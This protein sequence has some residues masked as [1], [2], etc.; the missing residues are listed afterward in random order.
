MRRPHYG[1]GVMVCQYGLWGFAHCGLER[2]LSIDGRGMDVALFIHLHH[3]FRIL[4]ADD[5][6]ASPFAKISGCVLGKSF[7]ASSRPDE[8]SRLR[9]ALLRV[10]SGLCTC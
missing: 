4:M 10:W 1:N 9:I 5:K 8:L 7:G 6:S 2:L 3:C